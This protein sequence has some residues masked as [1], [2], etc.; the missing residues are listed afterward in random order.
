MYVCSV[1][2]AIVSGAGVSGAGVSGANV[3]GR[4]GVYDRLVVWA[5]RLSTSGISRGSVV[6]CISSATSSVGGN[7]DSRNHKVIRLVCGAC[8]NST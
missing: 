3:F 8:T 4:G 5:N 2:S 1:G 7:V 6:T